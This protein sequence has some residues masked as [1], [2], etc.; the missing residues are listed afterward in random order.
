[1]QLSSSDSSAFHRLSIWLILPQFFSHLPY[2]A[3]LTISS[4]T[5]TNNSISA[6]ITG[7]SASGTKV[8]MTATNVLAGN[9]TQKEFD[10]RK[11]RQYCMKYSTGRDIKYNMIEIQLP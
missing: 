8:T 7:D 4:M 11:F 10:G 9:K 6:A 3:S 2:S 1:M 5:T